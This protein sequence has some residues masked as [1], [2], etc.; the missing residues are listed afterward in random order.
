MN[1]NDFDLKRIEKL[2]IKSYRKD[3]WSKFIKGIK[4]YNLVEENDK[5]A[6]A[7]SGGKDS[8]VLAKLFQELK[9]HSIL[10][11]ELEFL[12]MDPGFNKTNRDALEKNCKLLG[13]PVTII[14]SDIFKITKKISKDYPCY[15]CAKM[16]R[17][18]LYSEA[19]KLGCNK[20]ALGHHMDDIIETTLLNIF[21]AGTFKTMLPLVKSDNYKNMSLIRPMCFIKEKHIQ[22]FT[23]NTKL[24]PMNCGCEIATGKIQSKRNEMKD[25]IATLKTTNIDVD[26]CIYQSANNVKLDGVIGYFKDGKKHSFLD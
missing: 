19:K 6:V 12:S 21:Y 24:Q 8:L 22:N 4:T 2:I 15:M 1:N 5:I 11:F 13:I 23:I 10:N 25:L 18:F 7:I 14:N 16:R 20:L 3:L 9:K 17:G 26:K